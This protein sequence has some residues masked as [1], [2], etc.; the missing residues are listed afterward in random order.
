MTYRGTG[1][2]HRSSRRPAAL[3]T[4]AVIAVPAVVLIMREMARLPTG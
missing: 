4:A 2:E 1:Q 3:N